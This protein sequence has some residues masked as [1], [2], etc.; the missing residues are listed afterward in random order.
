MI[1]CFYFDCVVGTGM[2]GPGGSPSP[3]STQ[4]CKV[5]YRIEEE[6]PYEVQ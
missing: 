2:Q 1:R 6:A 5:T 4:P 3:R